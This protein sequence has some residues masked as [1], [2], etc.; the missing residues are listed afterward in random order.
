MI[1]ARSK[2]AGVTTQ[3]PSRL[4]NSVKN[5]GPEL[6]TC[7]N[8]RPKCVLVTVRAAPKVSRAGPTGENG[9]ESDSLARG[10]AH[11]SSPNSRSQ[12][13]VLS[14]RLSRG[15]P[16]AHIPRARRPARDLVVALPKN[17]RLSAR[18]SGRERPRRI[19]TLTS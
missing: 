10:P 19:A 8:T 6:L 18:V 13:A 3:T 1:K 9:L 11:Y 5:E 4:V 7:L 17:R 12:H 16:L 15:K 14:S 2:A